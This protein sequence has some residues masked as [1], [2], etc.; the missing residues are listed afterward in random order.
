MQ[1]VDGLVAQ[2]QAAPQEKADTLARLQQEA[3]AL[4]LIL[5]ELT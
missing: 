4:N 3:I 2:M 1:E 5:K